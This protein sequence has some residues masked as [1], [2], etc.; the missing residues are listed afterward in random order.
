MGFIP[1]LFLVVLILAGSTYYRIN[2]DELNLL[3]G[4]LFLSTL[5]SAAFLLAEATMK[6]VGRSKNAKAKIRLLLITFSIMLFVGEMFL[7]FGLNKY[8][9]YYEQNGSRNY[10]SIYKYGNTSWFHV[11]EANNNITWAKKELSHIRKTNSL[12]LSEKEIAKQKAANEYRI[13]ALGDSFT[14]GVGTSYD[15]TWVKVLEK[16]LSIRVPSRKVTTINAGVSGSDPVFEYVLLRERLVSYNPDLVIVAMNQS[17]VTDIIMRGGM[18]RFQPG[19]RIMIQQKGPYWEWVYGISYLFRHIIH[20]VLHYNWLLMKPDEISAKEQ[21]AT[22]DIRLSIGAFLNL[23]TKRNFSIVFVFHPH[24]FEI[25]DGKYSPGAFNDL[26][27]DL[28]RSNSA[29]IIDLLEYYRAKE[30]ITKAN[31]GDFFWRTDLHHNTRGYEAM[32]H[33]IADKI[34]E[35]GL[36]AS[37]NGD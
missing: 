32:G 17:D 2:A 23:A 12:G 21:T 25:K 24:E 11:H 15:S 33:G 13:I 16:D 29:H 6:M 5:C 37:V 18:E 10:L 30:I 34:A 26:I 27:A 22:E 36:L 35:F 1:L 3:T 8:S 31:S 28:K 19:E 9:N 7:R 20:D 14:E 4:V